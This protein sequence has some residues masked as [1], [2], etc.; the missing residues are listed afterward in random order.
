[1]NLARVL[2]RHVIVSLVRN[3][4]IFYQALAIAWIDSLVVPTLGANPVNVRQFA[5]ALGVD[6]RTMC[7]CKAEARQTK[8]TGV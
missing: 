2:L 1:M 3:M 5:D 8:N 6:A 4:V 7:N